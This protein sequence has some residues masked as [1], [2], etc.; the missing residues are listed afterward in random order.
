[1]ISARLRYTGTLCVALGSFAASI[2]CWVA[3]LWPGGIAFWLLSNVC[4]VAC[5]RIQTTTARLQEAHHAARVIARQAELLDASHCGEQKPS[6]SEH[7]QCTECVLRSGHPGSHA[8]EHGTRWW[9]IESDLPPTAGAQ[10]R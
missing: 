4:I 1:M 9:R 10:Q 3:A 7:T 8:D 5:G 2:Y 6:F